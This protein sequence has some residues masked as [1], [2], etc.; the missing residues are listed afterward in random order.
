MRNVLIAVIQLLSGFCSGPGDD[1]ARGPG[2]GYGLFDVWA[3]CR[4]DG[5][6]PWFC[7]AVPG[8]HENRESLGSWKR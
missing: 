1:D 2:C 3:K 4:N 7:G 8:T 6:V 5:G